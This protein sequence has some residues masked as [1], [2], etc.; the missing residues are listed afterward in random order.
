LIP[1]FRRTC[2]NERAEAQTGYALVP[3]TGSPSVELDPKSG[4]MRYFSV[5]GV[6]P[7][8]GIYVA[9]RDRNWGTVEPALS[10]L[11]IYQSARSFQVR[12]QGLAQSTFWRNRIGFCVLH[13]LRGVAGA[14]CTLQTVDGQ[15]LAAEFPR[16]IV[17]HQPCRQLR[18]ISH[19][20]A[21]LRTSVTMEG[22]TFE[23]EDQRNW[24]DA[25]FKTYCTPLDR[26][27][28]ALIPAGDG[29]A[30][31]LSVQVQSVR[32]DSPAIVRGN[33]TVG[34]EVGPAWTFPLPRLGLGMA[35]DGKPLSQRESEL[36]R[37]LHPAHLRVEIRLTEK[38]WEA[39]LQRA[40][41]EAHSIGSPLELSLHV[42]EGSGPD[43]SRMVRQLE[44]SEAEIERVLVHHSSARVTPEAWVRV[45]R[46][47]LG[48]PVEVGA[49]TY[50]ADLN[51][52]RPD[53]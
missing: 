5:Q 13:P 25:S 12:F 10:E 37:H 30:Q 39:G 16:L 33:G 41:Q 23:T 27:N 50:F 36:I 20:T 15:E 14:G 1:R 31:E 47:T 42:N 52:L 19:E 35:S 7:L 21:G 45:A 2:P 46:S 17:P 18:A 32:N 53:P 28:P 51:E 26:P 29:V 11:K 8:R 24:T 40:V 49:D 38:G 4:A 3:L 34:L 48:R 44:R 43:L 22:D 6:E 9:V